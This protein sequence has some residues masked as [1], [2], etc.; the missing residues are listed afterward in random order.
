MSII[1]DALRSGTNLKPRDGESLL[2]YTKRFN[3]AG[4]VSVSRIGGPFGPTKYMEK[5]GGYEASNAETVKKCKKRAFQQLLA[6][7]YLDN[8]VKNK[9]GSL[10]TALAMQ[11]SLGHDQ[12]PKSVTEANSVLSNHK[13]DA[14]YKRNEQQ[15]KKL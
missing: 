6:F 8:S 13:F 15:K 4:D 5:M 3:I 9:Y 11:Q 10:L 14:A 2:D 7:N 1:L 12:Y